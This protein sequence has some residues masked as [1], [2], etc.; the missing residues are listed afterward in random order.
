MTKKAINITIDEKLLEN[1]DTER[2]MIPRSPFIEH[3]I[4]QAGYKTM[5]LVE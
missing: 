2:G 5:V 1:I 3:L 4:V